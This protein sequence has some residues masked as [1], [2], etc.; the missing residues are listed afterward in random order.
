MMNMTMKLSKSFLCLKWKIIDL[1]VKHAT[2][3]ILAILITS[4]IVVKINSK[5]SKYIHIM[6]NI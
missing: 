2:L 6:R 4:P 5:R 3:H 1:T